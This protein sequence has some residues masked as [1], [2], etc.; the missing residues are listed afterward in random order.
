LIASYPK[1]RKQ[2]L[3][4]QTP[5]P[6]ANLIFVQKQMHRSSFQLTATITT[7]QANMPSDSHSTTPSP[8]KTGNG[9]D[10]TAPAGP[11]TSYKVIRTELRRPHEAPI[12]EK[13]CATLDEAKEMLAEYLNT[14]RLAPPNGSRTIVVPDDGLSFEVFR[15]EMGN[16]SR[17][18]VQKCWIEEAGKGDGVEKQLV[19]KEG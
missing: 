11:T 7:T 10:A 18:L 9:F 12:I 8:A 15:F 5:P 6:P 3:V 13:T 14:W 1:Y 17:V 16:E 4:C 2:L 19:E